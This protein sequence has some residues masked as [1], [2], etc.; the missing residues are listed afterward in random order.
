[1]DSVVKNRKPVF[2]KYCH[3]SYN[4]KLLMK[5]FLKD[6]TDNGRVYYTEQTYSTE[7]EINRLC[8]GEVDR[9]VFKE[10]P[11]KSIAGIFIGRHDLPQISQ[12]SIE[13][14]FWYGENRFFVLRHGF[15]KNGEGK[16][17]LF[18]MDE[19]V[20]REFFLLPISQEN[21][22]ILVSFIQK[23]LGMNIPLVVD[24]YEDTH[25]WI[26]V[27]VDDGDWIEWEFPKLQ[28]IGKT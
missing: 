9:L 22:R 26:E 18:G 28:L 15:L 10:N 14:E 3:W 7:E 17:I 20:P 16:P 23:L 19:Y 13:S 5:N 24:R 25:Y 1:M 11:C 4:D 6:Y 21:N 12:V 27:A 8:S 2:V